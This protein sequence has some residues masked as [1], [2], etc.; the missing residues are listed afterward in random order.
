MTQEE[1][2]GALIQNDKASRKVL[3]R[4]SA[5]L[6]ADEPEVYR[7]ILQRRDWQGEART[8]YKAYRRARA[9]SVIALI[10]AALVVIAS[11]ITGDF[12]MRLF[13]GWLN[14]Y[15]LAIGITIAM[16]LFAGSALALNHRKDTLIAHALL[17]R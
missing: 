12:G 10:L 15:A 2:R 4:L 6:E 8:A 1:I 14:R 16:A 13:T 3:A 9:Y 17:E 11:Y 5:E 7:D